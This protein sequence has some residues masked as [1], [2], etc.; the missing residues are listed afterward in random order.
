M[1][2]FSITYRQLIYFALYLIFQSSSFD[3]FLNLRIGG[4]SFRFVYII[5]LVLFGIYVLESVWQKRFVIRVLGLAP[6]LLWSLLL[7]VFIPNMPLTGRSIGY[8]MWLYIHFVFIVCCGYFVWSEIDV[9]KVVR[10]YLL[11]FLGCSLFGFVQ[12]IAGLLGYEL[13]LEQWW[14]EGVLPRLNGFSYEP[15]YYS[16]YLLIGFSLSYYLYRKG[17]GWYGKLP[18]YTS[19]ATSTAIF[20]SS[21]RMGILAV[22]IQI[23]CFEVITYRKKIK[24]LALFIIGFGVVVGSLF[25]YIIQ[26]ENL[27]FL[28][29]GLGIMGGSA[30]SAIERLDGFFTQIDIL[31]RNPFKGYSL[32]GVSQAIAFEKGV[33]TISQETIK[34]YDISMNVFL[35]VLTASGAIGFVFFLYYIYTLLISS[36]K[37]AATRHSH[38]SESILLNAFVWSLCFE[39]LILCFNQNILRAYLWVHIG[40]LNGV[41]F[42]VRNNNFKRFLTQ[43][44]SQQSKGI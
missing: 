5:M 14:I 8:L 12:L 2:D 43:Q 28:L 40:L 1:N 18:L 19:I 36:T 25:T 41:F 7:I 31:S 4:F 44:Q 17:M 22:I 34:P 13:L 26:N 10:L 37:K 38:D 21:S 39:F 16:T 42:F 33:T 32:G 35:E 23:L 30:H 9:Y 15:S 11:S 3:V 6:F 27:A 24:K 29:A 20:L